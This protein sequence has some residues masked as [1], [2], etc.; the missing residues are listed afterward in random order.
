M[1]CLDWRP[2]GGVVS[3]CGVACVRLA[4]GQEDQKVNDLVA[5]HGTKKWSLIG[6]FLTGRTGKQCRERY[7]TIM[8]ALHS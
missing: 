4:M 3:V 2:C 6:S 8:M 5:K 7:V 1:A